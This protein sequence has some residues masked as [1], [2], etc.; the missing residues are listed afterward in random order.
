[1]TG[2]VAVAP[3]AVV[4]ET[5]PKTGCSWCPL[6]P[7]WSDFADYAKDYKRDAT[8]ITQK[9]KEPHTI[10]T[11]NV[12]EEWTEVDVLFVGEAPGALE[13]KKGVPFVG[14]SGS[15]LRAGV[16]AIEGVRVGFTNPVRCRPPGNRTPSDT[17]ARSCASALVDEIRAR[18]PRL[19]VA[20][21]NTALWSLASETGITT[22]TG[23]VLKCTISEFAHIPVLACLHPAYV[24]RFDHEV[25]RMAAALETAQ[26][27]LR[28]E[29]TS[30]RGLGTYH[31]AKTADEAIKWLRKFMRADLVAHDTETGSLSFTQTKWP[32]LLCFSFSDEEG[33]GYVI[34]F[35]H[36]ECTFDAHDKKRV[37]YWLKKYFKS[38]VRKAAQNEKYDRNHIRARLGVEVRNVVD[39]MMQHYVINETRGTHG[40]D[41]TAHVYTGMGG[42]DKQLTD[43]VA[44][45][46]DADP[47]RGGSYA[48]IPG[49]VLFPYSGQDADATRRISVALPKDEKD[50]TRARRR[51]AEVFY[52]KFSLALSRMEAAGAHIDPSAAKIL[53]RYYAS[54]MVCLHKSLG[55]HV[56]VRQFLRMRAR[57][58]EVKGDT[59]AIRKAKEP[60]N[61]K[62]PQQ[63]QSV[64][65]LHMKERPRELTKTGLTFT[66]TRLQRLQK[67]W[68]ALP[69][70]KRRRTPE[71][72]REAIVSELIAQGDVSGF[73]TKA[74]VLQEMERD[75]NDVCATLLNYRH[76]ATLKGTFTTPMLAQVEGD[77]KL[78]STFLMHGTGTSRLASR[79]PNL[80]NVPIHDGVKVVSKGASKDAFNH[81]GVKNA[82]VSRFGRDGLLLSADQS[83]VELRVGAAFYN[84]PVMIEAYKRGDDLHRLTAI[85]ISRLSVAKFDALPKE[86]KKD[87]RTRAKRVNF[88]SLF[89]G[90]PGALMRTLAKDG[91]FITE[92]EAQ[93]LLHRF[94][95]K[96]PGLKRGIERLKAQVRRD[97]YVEWF[98]GHKRRVQEV[99]SSDE[100]QVA[101]ALR[102]CVNAP[103]QGGAGMLTNMSLTLIDRDM[104]R[105]KM[106]SKLILTVHD[107]II[108]DVLVD[109]LVDLAKLVRD[110]ME[111]VMHYSDEVLPG[112]DWKWL[113]VPLRA[114]F[115]SGFRWGSD[116]EWR[117][118]TVKRNGESITRELT[119][120]DL[121]IDHLWAAMTQA[122][123][124]AVAELRTYR[125]RTQAGAALDPVLLDA[126]D[127]DSE[128]DDDEGG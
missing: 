93:E 90:G 12:S 34:P 21:G 119:L 37:A 83:Q 60:F 120:D 108:F 36:K 14:K 69:S 29:Y 100:E 99:F 45:H 82:Y 56:A 54:E 18:R 125:E 62:S 92:E 87:W 89:G 1:M 76:Y 66:S 33:K 8:K 28:G 104:R 20:L 105:L 5:E 109:E 80:Q 107:S 22:H 4:P 72:T 117:E 58:A 26:K 122:D 110:R 49:C 13:D 15:L 2:V 23:H 16:S 106:G 94:F 63:L 118:A 35:D 31:V 32:R 124:A 121:D 128:E 17:I 50:Y 126:E 95:E 75:G 74:S 85:D 40:L 65:F 71:P 51:L 43:Y 6:A 67:E 39:V 73:S 98:T 88:G 91:V 112:L 79:R 27:I 113:T 3:R 70:S 81:G 61:P 123:E 59:A 47:S 96:R 111:N 46:A 44:A 25:E 41:K 38:S 30:R 103:V 48:N 116:I 102:Q 84:E 53:D 86:V 9:E 68:R 77:K 19:L 10:H 42:Y 52:P 114:D 97:G 115:S 57:K 64:L 127:E 11:R 101:R 24:L 55:E 7:F 78:R